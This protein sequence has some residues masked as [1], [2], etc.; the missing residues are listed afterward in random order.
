MALWGPPLTLRG[1]L[2]LQKTEKQLE[3]I[4]ELHLEYAKR[5]APFNNWMES[6][7]ED[8][9][10]MF[11]VHTIEE[12]E[13]GGCSAGTSGPNGGDEL[14]GHPRGRPPAHAVPH[15]PQG[16]IAAH[17]Q[18]KATLPDADREREAILGIQREAQ[19]IADLH[20]I[21]LSGNNPYTS[22]TPQVINSKW[23]RVSAAAGQLGVCGAARG[24][25][26][27]SGCRAALGASPPPPGTAPSRSTETPL[28][29][30]PRCS[31]WC[32]RGTAR[33]RTSRAGSSATSGC[34]GSLQGRP[35]SW[36]R[37]C[38]PRWR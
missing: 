15:N 33:C 11:I 26:G 24:V 12:I 17:D 23:E 25:W 21:K 4:D 7:M 1:V 2:S 19:R 5:A 35:T 22:V 31:S 14:L 20:S 3:T 27:S 28:C 13:V 30:P 38:R 9:Q 10:D 32:P 16:L 18:F 34:G 6:A 29:A 37:G 36:G 8:L